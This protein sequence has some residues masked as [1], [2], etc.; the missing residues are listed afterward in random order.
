M[1]LSSRSL[2]L[3]MTLGLLATANP[4]AQ[5]Q[6][7][8][9]VPNPGL[10]AVY[11]D[12]AIVDPDTGAREPMP[13]QLVA[14]DFAAVILSR[15]QAGRHVPA[16]RSASFTGPALTYL[17][18]DEVE[19][20]AGLASSTDV[21]TADQANHRAYT[22]NVMMD[23][24]A[25]CQVHDSIV[26]GAQFDHDLNQLT[27]DIAATADWFLT[28]SDTGKRFVSNGG[29]RGSQLYMP[30][31]ANQHFR[32]YW[33]ARAVREFDQSSSRGPS[34]ANDGLFIDNVALNWSNVV[35]HGSK[36]R[37]VASST[38]YASATEEFVTQIRTT[39]KQRGEH[40]VWGNLIGYDNRD[41]D[42]WDS[43]A[44]LLDGA[45]MED[46]VTRWGRSISDPEILL[47]QIEIAERWQAQ[48]NHFMGV[49][50]SARTEILEAT[51]DVDDT[52]GPFGFAVSLMVADGTN[53][54]FHYGNG[55]DYARHFDLAEY[56]MDLG[57]P[58]GPKRLISETLYRR[59]FERGCVEVDVAAATSSIIPT[60]CSDDPPDPEQ[61]RVIGSTQQA[62]QGKLWVLTDGK[63][64]GRYWHNDGSPSAYVQFELDHE[65]M[66]T[67]LRIA[68]HTADKRNFRYRVQTS[69]DGLNFTT[70]YEGFEPSYTTDFQTYDLTDGPAR[71][72][73]VVAQGYVNRIESRWQTGSW[74]YLSE[75]QLWGYQTA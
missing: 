10:A 54:S 29:A 65:V 71:F 56:R 52:W 26:T 62:G 67:H 6:Q 16:Y 12:P 48:G 7:D 24:G 38:E 28:R 15:D 60:R 72:V 14:Q 47:S 25:F 59:T 18:L 40:L 55:D 64:V 27:P 11:H 51:P 22:N 23:Q 4:P 61:Q 5:A 1:K 49:V 33:I 58:V 69:V 42:S 50:P 44:S 17:I 57:D 75:V 37:Q 63:P 2:A 41:S 30:N 8:P 35:R 34:E 43:Y 66:L 45:M 3:L 9:V 39:I 31:P 20:P 21:C 73:R 13:D 68:A 36:P 32:E 53:M 46:F 19:G 70:V 74:A